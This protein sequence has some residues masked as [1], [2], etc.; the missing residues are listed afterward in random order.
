[1]RNRD[2]R[3]GLDVKK[4][5]RTGDRLLNRVGGAGMLV[6]HRA[7]DGPKPSRIGGPAP[8]RQSPASDHRRAASRCHMAS[9]TCQP[10]RCA[11]GTTKADA[12]VTLVLTVAAYAPIRSAAWCR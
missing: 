4:T 10:T 3:A 12:I 8:G 5:R 6:R 7:R 1:M 11:I 2:L 9:D